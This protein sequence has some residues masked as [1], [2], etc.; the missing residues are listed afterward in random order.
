MV[1][2]SASRAYDHPAAV[3]AVN[4]SPPASPQT[5]GLSRHKLGKITADDTDGRSSLA[6]STKVAGPARIVSTKAAAGPIGWPPAGPS[7]L[8][9][10]PAR[11]P[12][13]QRQPWNMISVTRL[14]KRYGPVVAV[15]DATFT[16]EPGTAITPAPSQGLVGQRHILLLPTFGSG[17][18]PTSTS[19]DQEKTHGR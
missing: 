15:D 19:T 10:R 17:W 4:R 12:A 3:S 8:A 5:A 13:R 14:S 2:P 7:T 16:C 11:W 9:V 18:I 6:A 1:V